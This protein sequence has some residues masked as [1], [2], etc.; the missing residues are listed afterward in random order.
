MKIPVN[1]LALF[2]TLAV[3]SVEAT[4]QEGAKRQ[5]ESSGQAPTLP[6][7]VEIYSGVFVLAGTLESSKVAF[8]RT[9]GITHV[10]SLRKP[11]EGD[12]AGEADGLHVI[13]V[14][15]A[16]CPTDREP[17]LAEIDAFRVRMKALPPRAKVLVHCATGN[18]AA[19]LLMAFWVLD[20]SMPKDE[21]LALA[22]KA[23]LKNPATET[24]VLAH[25]TART[26]SKSQ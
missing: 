1:I 25:L 5:V 3:L 13:G 23:G 20:K 24:A 22:H 7:P 6:A 10:I 21:A 4:A 11:T 12:F 18:R 15:Y 14:E 9:S 2:G 26:D 17:T 16:S 19:G 8:L